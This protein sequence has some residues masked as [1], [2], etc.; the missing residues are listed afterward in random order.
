MANRS[1]KILQS[2]KFYYDYIDEIAA[3][4]GILYKDTTSK[5]HITHTQKKALVKILSASCS[6]CILRAVWNVSWCP[7]MFAASKC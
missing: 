6:D 7:G 2:I 4:D 1:S 5:Y 3:C